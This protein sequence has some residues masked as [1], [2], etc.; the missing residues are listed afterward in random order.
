M[1]MD[2]LAFGDTFSET[3][4]IKLAKKPEEGKDPEENLIVEGFEGECEQCQIEKLKKPC[5][6]C[7]E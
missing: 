5:L 1:Q 2:S 6:I 7:E 3:S 4:K